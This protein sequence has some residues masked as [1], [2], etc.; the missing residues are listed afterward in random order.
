MKILVVDN[1][2]GSRRLLCDLLKTKGVECIEAETGSKEL[3]VNLSSEIKCCVTDIMMP[4]MNGYEL[5]KQIREK[6]PEIYIIATTAS[7]SKM[8]MIKLTEMDLFDDVLLKPIE[9]KNFDKVF[10]IFIEECAKGDIE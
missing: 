7:L 10:N 4:E 9:L 6:Y 2:E 8:D 5:A 3:V 1:D